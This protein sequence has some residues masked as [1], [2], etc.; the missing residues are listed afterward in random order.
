[1]KLSYDEEDFHVAAE[2]NF[3]ATSYGKSPC[4]GNGRAGK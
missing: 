2:W 1:V 3:F 4:K